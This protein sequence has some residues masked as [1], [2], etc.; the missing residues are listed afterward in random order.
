[1][2]TLSLP[3]IGVLALASVAHGQVKRAPSARGGHDSAFAAMQARGKQAMGV[4]Q[5]AS[6]HRFDALPDGGRI[7]LVR[8]DGDSADVATIRAHLREI[9]RAFGA[10]DFSTPILV[11][12][13]PV[14]GADVMAA[15]RAFITYEARDIPRGA[16]LRIRTSDPRALR[17]IHDFMAFQRGEH[18]AS[19]AP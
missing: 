11:H 2:R 14:P 10:G 18:H 5:Y 9:A 17:A 15:R 3:M 6:T 12:R 1:M 4:D 13:R 16:E 7:E 19:G 8:N